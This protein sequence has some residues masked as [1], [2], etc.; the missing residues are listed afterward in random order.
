MKYK[1]YE[2]GFLKMETDNIIEAAK[3]ASACFD[4]AYIIDTT[5][6]ERVKDW[7]KLI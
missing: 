5:T 7:Y 2:C 4:Y 6:G 1:V 3:R